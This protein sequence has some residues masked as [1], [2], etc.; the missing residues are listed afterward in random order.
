MTLTTTVAQRLQGN[1]YR[2]TENK[3]ADPLLQ[4]YAHEAAEEYDRQCRAFYYPDPPPVK[5]VKA[6][7]ATTS[8]VVT[9]PNAE[10]EKST[11]ELAKVDHE[12]I[13]AK[14]KLTAIIEQEKRFEPPLKPNAL[15]LYPPTVLGFDRARRDC[16]WEMIKIVK[17]VDAVTNDPNVAIDPNRIWQYLHPTVFRQLLPSPDPPLPPYTP[18]WVA[19][20]KKSLQDLADAANKR[21]A[22]AETTAANQATKLVNLENNLETS[23][24][25]N[26]T[27]EKAM[28]GLETD[29]ENLTRE[30][31]SF[32]VAIATADQLVKQREADLRIFKEAQPKTQ[33]DL[34]DLQQKKDESD[35][36]VSSLTTQN[37][38]LDRDVK[39]HLATISTLNMKCS[40]FEEERTALSTRITNYEKS[41]D[42]VRTEK[43]GLETKLKEHETI[44]TTNMVDNTKLIMEKTELARRISTLEE[45]I[46]DLRLSTDQQKRGLDGM[47]SGKTVF[48]LNVADRT[49]AWDADGRKYF[50]ALASS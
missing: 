9:V 24:K 25:E 40:T 50:L 13:V 46:S 29:K 27:L 49:T 36:M 16:R 43:T 14:R 5:A 47:Y 12:I 41:L 6:I 19:Q 20:E 42:D 2:Y 26:T 30:N 34:L 48:I 10:L 18:E 1:L 21:A 7:T 33:Q 39:T 38:D 11:L 28:K 31:L 22:E 3:S 44:L 17:E 8:A 15:V 4:S 32:V 45:Q 23:K 37:R 35:R